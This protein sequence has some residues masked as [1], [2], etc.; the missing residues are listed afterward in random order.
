MEERQEQDRSRYAA[1]VATDAYNWYKIAAVRSRR[2]HRTSELAIVVLSAAIPI[3]AIAAPGSAS[4][5][6]VLGS[7]IAVVTGVRAT[8]RWSEN[9]LRFSKARES[10]VAERRKFDVGAPPY[11]DL[12]T[13]DRLLVEAITAVEQDELS[14]WLEIAQPSQRGEVVQQPPQER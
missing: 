7:L 9:Y 5:P 8:F 6:A 11:G 2:W 14:R 3:C 13:R 1:A 12:T 4:L 10:V